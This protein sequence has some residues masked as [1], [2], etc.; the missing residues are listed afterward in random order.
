[1]QFRDLK[2][3]YRVLK[4]EIDTA[5]I[6]VATDSNFISGR[7]VTELEN[8]LAEYVGVKHCVTFGN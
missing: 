1:M 7:Q 5:M 8:Q 3:Q 4:N 2:E 6:R